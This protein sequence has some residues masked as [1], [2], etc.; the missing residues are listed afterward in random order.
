MRRRV[1]LHYTNEEP[2]EEESCRCC[3]DD[4]PEAAAGCPGAG[5]LRAGS[6]RRP[7]RHGCGPAVPPPSVL[8]PEPGQQGRESLLSPPGPGKTLPAPPGPHARPR[9][10][11]GEPRLSSGGRSGLPTSPLPEPRDIP[12]FTE[13]QNQTGWKRLLRSSSPTHDRTPAHQDHQVPH[14]VLPLTLP[15]MVTTPPPLPHSSV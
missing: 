7:E 6:E 15:R 11:L 5:R 3:Q 9:L 14:P 2:E 12:C 8:P 4:S 10:Q 13:P 1:T